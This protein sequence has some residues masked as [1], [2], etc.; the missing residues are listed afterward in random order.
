M[1][2]DASSISI[3]INRIIRTDASGILDKKSQEASE[4]AVH[5]LSILHEELG[6]QGW[7]ELPEVDWARMK[8]FEFQDLLRQR[9]VLMDRLAK[10][11]CQVCPD[12]DE[13]V[14]H[15]SRAAQV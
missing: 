6:G 7:G 1:A 8:Q 12:F 13:H 10:M 14:S 4:E 15:C 9:G 3:V 11:G 5:D 2:I